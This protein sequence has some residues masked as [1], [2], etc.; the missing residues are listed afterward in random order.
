MLFR[1]RQ[2]HAF[3]ILIDD[4]DLDAD[5]IELL[6]KT[7]GTIEDLDKDLF[8]R[9]ESMEISL[10]TTTKTIKSYNSLRYCLNFY[11]NKKLDIL[12]SKLIKICPKIC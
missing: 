4:E 3:N 1:L 9:E 5:I 11:F 7:K 10:Q 12:L 6:E 8:I 2:I